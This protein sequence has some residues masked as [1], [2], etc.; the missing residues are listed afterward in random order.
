MRG[1]T[2]VDHDESR[3]RQVVPAHAGMD[4][5]S[6]APDPVPH[7]CP[8]ACGDGPL[9]AQGTVRLPPLSPR[10]R[11]WTVRTRQDQSGCMGCPRACGDGPQ[12]TRT[13]SIRSTLS[14]RMRGWTAARALCA[15]R[16]C[17]V[18]AHAGMDRRTPPCGPSCL[19][20]PR[21]CGDGPSRTLPNG[22]L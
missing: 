19:R 8:R 22:A 14:P 6:R 7:G 21:A 3:R 1:W 15:L 10:M 9:M 11:G 16:R 4:R 20:C 2:G 13:R 18:P 5:V 17:V 12:V